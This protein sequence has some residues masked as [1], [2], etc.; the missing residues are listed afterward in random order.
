MTVSNGTSSSTG[1]TAAGSTSTPSWSLDGKVA[2]VTGSSKLAKL[3]M[4][5]NLCSSLKPA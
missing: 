2:L 5:R 4:S 1:Q 3:L